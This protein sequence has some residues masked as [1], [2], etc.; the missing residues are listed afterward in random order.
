MATPVADWPT[1]LAAL[2]GGTLL[3]G[4]A[5][6]AAFL[7]A[8]F[9]GSLILPG[10]R[11]EGPELDGKSISYK[12][13]GLT[14]FLLTAVVAALAQFLGWFS[15]SVL[16]THFLALFVVTNVFAFAFSGWLYWRS[17]AQGD[18]RV[19]RRAS[20]VLISSASNSIRPCSAWISRCSATARR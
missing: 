2:S 13:N 14:L 5:M 1:N 9:L 7:A 10:R 20:G 19:R 17:G 18:R 12:L 8:M 6:L 4:A 11:I 16:N 3:A 15:L